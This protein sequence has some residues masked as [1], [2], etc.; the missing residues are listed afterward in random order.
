MPAPWATSAAINWKARCSRRMFTGA[1]PAAPTGTK[2]LACTPRRS[3]PP[4]LGWLRCPLR[5][6][7]GCR[8]AEAHG[9]P[10]PGRA[11]DLDVPI[12]KLD[13]F[14]DQGEAE[15]CSFIFSRQGGFHLLEGFEHQR[16]LVRF[17]PDS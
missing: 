7:A 11:A 5:H 10:F 1:A 17:D 14:L 2:S 13:E 12:V 3:P 8:K 4:A 15:T 9:R 16:N 6:I